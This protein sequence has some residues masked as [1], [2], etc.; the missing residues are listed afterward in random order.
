VSH[1]AES[2][3][4]G[5]PV[6]VRSWMVARSSLIGSIIPTVYL[7]VV[8]S[9]LIGFGTYLLISDWKSSQRLGFVWFVVVG[10]V[11]IGSGLL[12]VESVARRV[13]AMDSGQFR[14]SSRRRSI[15]VDPASLISMTGLGRHFDP[16]GFY[17]FLMKS[18][19]G[20]MYV[21]RHMRH[22]GEQEGE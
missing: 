19:S 11:A 13:D 12:N 20:S 6:V 17:P 22:G 7:P 15:M 21:N 3:P 2:S 10:C 16:L 1:Q 8:G 14:F 9:F 5:D 18:G 4:L